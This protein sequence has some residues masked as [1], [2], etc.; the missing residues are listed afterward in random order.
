MH[1]FLYQRSQADFI[2]AVI[3]T[4]LH[5]HLEATSP[6]NVIST[7][8]RTKLSFLKWLLP[9]IRG[10]AGCRLLVER[11]HCWRVCCRLFGFV[12]RKL[13]GSVT[14]NACHVFAELDAEQPAEA[15]ANFVM[16]VML[17]HGRRRT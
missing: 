17:G 11:G 1:D 3:R 13:G 6:S 5:C 4:D 9:A 8:R 14:D 12:G 16:K 10:S 2:A 7:Q 15:V